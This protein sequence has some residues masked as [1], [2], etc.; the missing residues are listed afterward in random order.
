VQTIWQPEAVVFVGLQ[1]SGKSSLYKQRFFHSHVRINLDMLRTRHRE[2]LLL[3]ACIEMKQIFV[4]DNTNPT[5]AER[6]KYI[7]PARRARFRVVGYYFQPDVPGCIARNQQRTG[8]ERVPP[9][10]IVATAKRLQPPTFAE[11]FDALYYVILDDRQGFMIQE[12]D[13]T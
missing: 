11:G 3:R 1:G 6:A 10:A 12:T 2:T 9:Q 8:R 5:I 7:E 13:P 4:V